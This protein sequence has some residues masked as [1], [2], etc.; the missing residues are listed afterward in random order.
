MKLK[1]K[2]NLSIAALTV[3]IILMFFFA[4]KPLFNQIG[5]NSKELFSQKANL[6]SLADKIDNL[7]KLEKVYRDYEP[8]FK[9]IDGLFID[10]EV[11]VEFIAFL[12]NV[13]KECSLNVKI[14]PSL[15]QESKEYPWLFVNFQINANGSFP[16]FLKFLEK[17]ENSPYLTEIQGISITK[18]SN[19]EDDSEAEVKAVFSVKVYAKEKI[20][21]KD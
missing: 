8:D 6:V 1:Q 13:V 11:P 7:R 9:K 2:I 15:S 14:S 5:E 10:S 18:T 20:N 17:L 4:V 21:E 19:E 12:E 3:L 16:N